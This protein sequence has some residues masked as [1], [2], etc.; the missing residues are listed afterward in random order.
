M[1]SVRIGCRIIHYSYE[2]PS[3]DKNRGCVCLIMATPEFDS[4]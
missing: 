4:Q 2:S 1:V 3:K